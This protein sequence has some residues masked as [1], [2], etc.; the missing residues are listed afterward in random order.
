MLAVAPGAGWAQGDFET[1][2]LA[3]DTIYQNGPEPSIIV[4]LP[5]NGAYYTCAGCNTYTSNFDLYISTGPTSPPTTV[6]ARNTYQMTTAVGGSISTALWTV[7]A[8]VKPN[9][10]FQASGNCASVTQYKM[11]GFGGGAAANAPQLVSLQGRLTD[12]TTGAALTGTYSMTFRIFDAAT[13]GTQVWTETQSS[14]Q[15]DAGV[16][17]VLLGSVMPLNGSHFQKKDAWLEVTVSGGDP[18]VT[19]TL[20]PRKRIASVPYSLTGGGGAGGL[21]LTFIDNANNEPITPDGTRRT[22]N[23]GPAGS[24]KVPSTA[25]HA[26]LYITAGASSANSG[27]STSVSS[28]SV[29]LKVF[30]S[31]AN[32]P[33]FSWARTLTG[34]WK[35]GGDGETNTDSIA[36]HV[37]VPLNPNQEL[38][39]QISTSGTGAASLRVVGYATQAA[40]GG[41]AA[42][43]AIPSGFCI[44]SPTKNTCPAGWV[45]NETLNAGRTIRGTTTD[46][47][48]TGGAESP[49]TS[50]ASGG[51]GSY[52]Y[53]FTVPLESNWPPY[54]NVLICCKA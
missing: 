12:K 4:A 23:I 3:C 2:T 10:Y 14:V 18:V 30:A 5:T 34:V 54:T 24:G 20:A 19:E 49:L 27:T 41:A 44:F 16:F 25:T 26:L 9:Y 13:G 53:A 22:L 38:E 48:S 11:K 40:G 28:G 17:N 6:V 32:N 8:P 45:A 36:S 50:V 35:S 33:V 39:Y 21:D 42:G 1:V 15:V 51:W 7:T 29:D 37:L 46:V 47:G 52:A 43:G 31:G